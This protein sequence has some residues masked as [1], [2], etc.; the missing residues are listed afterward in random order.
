MEEHQFATKAIKTTQRAFENINPVTAPIYLSTTFKRNP[1]GSYNDGFVYTRAD[2]PNRRILEQSLAELEGGADAFA[3]SSGMAAVSALFQS[4]SPTDH[5]L[6]PDDIYFNIYLLVDEVFSRWGLTYTLVDMTDLNALKAAFRP[7]TRL[8]W[9]E[10][11]SNP[12]LKITDIAEVATIAHDQG[13]L[14]VV[15][16]TWPTPVLQRPFDLGA[17]IVMHSTTKY[18]GGH[19]DVLG[20][21]II[22]RQE[23]AYTDR[24]AKVQ[25]FSGAVP[26]PFDCWLISR[27]I[28]TMHLRVHAQS[29]SA[30]ELASFLSQHPRIEKVNYPGL[31]DHAGYEIA[32]RQMPNG[33]GGMLSILV[34]GDGER[35]LQVSNRLN[36]FTTA[37][38]LGGVESLVEHRKSIEGPSSQTPDNLLRISV[39]L[40][41]IGDLIEDWDQAL[42]L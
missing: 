38:S 40:E 32:R 29:N 31:S 16:N 42:R 28:Q 17:D 19:S 14:I 34:K 20:G 35:A 23:S 12:Q 37:T 13:A 9:L 3:F 21:C 10:T 15:D 33:A 6:L 25:V 18:F 41:D 39:G 36:V 5:I 1:D 27:G 11:P 8:V 24:V 26:S 30:A 4:L 7:N 22:L 2:N